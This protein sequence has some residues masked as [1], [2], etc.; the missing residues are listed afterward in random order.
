M[1][2]S[3]KKNLDFAARDYQ[4]ILITSSYSIPAAWTNASN[5][6][7]T[8]PRTGRFKITASGVIT[9][10]ESSTASNVVAYCRLAKGG[11][12]ITG[13]ARSVGIS[14][15]AATY[16]YNQSPFE[17]TWEDDF[18]AGDVITLQAAYL[19]GAGNECTIGYTAGAIEPF[20][21]Y[22]SVSA[23]VPVISPD[24]IY[25]LLETDTGRKW[26]GKSIYRKVIDFGL[27]PNTAAKNVA[28]GITTLEKVVTYYGIADNGT[29]QL[30]IP[31][32]NTA[33]LAFSYSAYVDQ[34]NV[35][36][37]T[38]GATHIAYYAYII[39]EYTKA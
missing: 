30:P 37:T 6:T 21:S 17:L 11:V 16:A 26:L 5:W 22:E 7:I 19:A 2:S 13:T 31:H 24:N 12:A 15:N 29:Y 25:S 38:G 4:R 23:Y 10:S 8:I 36:I 14:I 39:V 18:V 9:A 20:M 33:G 34:T 27:L 1:I 3:N 32:V 28:H 35:N